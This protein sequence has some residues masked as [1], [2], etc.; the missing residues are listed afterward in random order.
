MAIKLGGLLD[1]A[2][3]GVLQ[4]NWSIGSTESAQ[5]AGESK[6]EKRDR[7][8]FDRKAKRKGQETSSTLANRGIYWKTGGALP[9]HY[10]KNGELSAKAVGIT[11]DAVKPSSP[12]ET[13]YE[14]KES[15][16]L[17]ISGLIKGA[18]DGLIET[19]VESDQGKKAKG[20]IF[21]A[22]LKKNVGYALSVLLLIG[23]VVYY[24][25]NKSRKPKWSKR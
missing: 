20:D 22:W 1:T 8:A 19:I 10:A 21:K 25:V 3:G 23:M 15:A 13:V 11:K 7:K 17:S 5:F 14:V 9:Y 12:V 2:T 6:S 24:F 18:K 4:T 16:P